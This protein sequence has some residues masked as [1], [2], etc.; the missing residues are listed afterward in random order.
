MKGW[1][2]QWQLETSPSPCKEFSSG[3]GNWKCEQGDLLSQ[4]TGCDVEK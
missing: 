3:D 1:L 4:K 2:P